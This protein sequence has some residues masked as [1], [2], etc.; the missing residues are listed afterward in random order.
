MYG[1]ITLPGGEPPGRV[2]AAPVDAAATP[3]QPTKADAGAV[4]AD[5][6]VWDRLGTLLQIVGAGAAIV[7]WVV[8]VGGA[9]MWAR[10]QAAHVPR[11]TRTV[12]LVPRDA[13]A[14][15][16]QKHPHVGNVKQQ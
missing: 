7:T 6:A 11:P 14:S 2:I 1:P 13:L 5:G 15:G 12:T 10:L 3:N 9:V 4:P 16:D 8:L